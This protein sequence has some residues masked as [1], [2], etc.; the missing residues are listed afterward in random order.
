MAFSVPAAF[1]GLVDLIP[2]SVESATGPA[3]AE[4]AAQQP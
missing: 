1:A 2:F 3:A 4:D